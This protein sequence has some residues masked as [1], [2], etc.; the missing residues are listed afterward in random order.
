M[1][2]TLSPETVTLVF[3]WI[4]VAGFLTYVGVYAALCLGFCAGDSLR[5]F[6]GNTIAA[7]LVLISLSAEFNL[8]SAMIQCFWIV[9]G[10]TA[11]V[12]RLAKRA[13][14]RRAAVAVH[15]WDV[16]SGPPNAPRVAAD[17]HRPTAS[18]YA[19]GG[20]VPKSE[21]TQSREAK[22]TLRYL[23]DIAG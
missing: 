18:G 16:M 3:R 8:A 11:I 12:L 9:M 5:Y 10:C 19:A 22:A 20:H 17:R 7:G 15:G 23:T 14:D 6:S 4:G 2:E 13:S 1:L 21:T